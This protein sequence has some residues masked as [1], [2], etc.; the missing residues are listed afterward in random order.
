MGTRSTTKQ[1]WKQALGQITCTNQFEDSAKSIIEYLNKRKRP[2]WLSPVLHYLPKGH[3]FTTTVYLIV[4][5]DNIVFGEDAALN[6]NFR[7]FRIDNR[8]AIYYP[9]HELSHAGYFRY[10]RMPDLAGMKTVSDLLG[11]IKLLAHLEGMGVI[12]PLKLRLKEGGLLDNDYRTLLD[13]TERD[14]RIDDYFNVISS[15]EKNR[16]RKLRE[17][18]FQVLEQ[19]SGKTNRLWYITGC[20]MAQEIEEELGIQTLRQ[21]VKQGPIEFFENYINLK[22]HQYSD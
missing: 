15:L 1:F 3:V 11:A 19:M 16:R 9:I 6:L 2:D 17:H 22:N 5:Y 13:S 4:G 21:L 20:K 18:D 14:R 10:Q 12:S 8:E 7:Q